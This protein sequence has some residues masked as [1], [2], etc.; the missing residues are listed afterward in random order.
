MTSA[1]IVF[2]DRYGLHPRAAMRI[3]QTAAP[4]RSRVSIA[5]LEGPG[6]ELD[7]RSMIALVSAGIRAGDRIRVTADGPDEADALRAVKEL[8]GAGVCHP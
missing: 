1:D 5:S 8:I 6:S 4:F 7:A 2:R 3:Q